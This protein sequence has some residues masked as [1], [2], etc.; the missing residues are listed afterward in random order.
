[1]PRV[2]PGIVP[3]LA[4][5]PCAQAHCSR[6]C[7]QHTFSLVDLLCASVADAPVL[8]WARPLIPGGVP[9]WSSVLQ[10]KQLQ[11]ALGSPR[12]IAYYADRPASVTPVP[13]CCRVSS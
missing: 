7:A 8:M 9:I 2:S 10:W 3:Y 1:M 13:G 12:P 11:G 4:G 6:A 5:L